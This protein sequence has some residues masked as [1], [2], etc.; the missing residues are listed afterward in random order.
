[1]FIMFVNIIF[2][3]FIVAY[4]T[5]TLKYKKRI[6][7]G[8]DEHCASFSHYVKE[9]HVLGILHSPFVIC[10]LADKHPK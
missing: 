7:E 6:N 8:Y 4:L 5:F 9:A 2:S 10:F 3:L 1:M